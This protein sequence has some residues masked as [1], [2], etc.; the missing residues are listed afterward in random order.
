MNL[1][2]KN[3]RNILRL[4]LNYLIVMKFAI[5]L[6]A[7]V[8]L[9]STYAVGVNAQNISISKKNASIPSLLREIRLQTGYD[10]FFEENTL[11][12][13]KTVT[14]HIKNGSLDEVL[15]TVFKGQPFT[16][17]VSQ[18][19]VIIK[20]RGKV[21]PLKETNLRDVDIKIAGTV[22]DS[23]GEPLVGVSIKVKGTSVGTVTNMS[24]NYVIDASTDAI[25]VF[26]YVG[27][28]TI[29]VPVQGRTAI[30]I[31]MQRDDAAISEVVVVGF[32][33][34]KKESLVG[35][36]S[37]VKAT[38][39]KTPARDLTTVLAGRLA[40]VVATQRSGAPGSD[41]ATL[42]IRGVGT[43][44]SS[45]QG[46]LLVVD[47]VPDRAI[48]NIDPEDIESFTILKDATATAVYGTRGANGV[49]LINTKRGKL[50]K[51]Q[52]NA[53]FNQALTRF[54]LLPEFLDGPE[55][56][57]LYNEG[58]EMR[59][60]APLY[61]TEII[62]NHRSREDPDLY[63]NVDWYSVLFNK[64]GHN[65]RATLN[66]NGGSESATYYISAGYFGEVGLF[67]TDDI[68][69][70]N[71]TL[72]LDRFN[73]TSNVGV[74]ITKST[75][76]ELGINGFIT[77]VN[78]PAYGINQIFALATSTAPHVIPP[79]YSNGLWPQLSGTQIS[80]YMAL[81]QSGINNSYQTAV[82]SNLRVKQDLAMVLDGLSATGMFAFDVN[83]TNS[84]ARSRTLQTYYASGRDDNGDLITSITTPGTEELAFSI[85]RYGDRRFYSEA[86]L[87]YSH[88]FG[89]HDV[90]GLLLFN[91]SDYADATSRVSSYQAAI[92]Y[93][94]RNIVGRANYG[95]DGRYY[96]EANFSY[97][98]SDNFVPGKRF[99]FFPSFGAGW[100][101]SREKWYEGVS[102]YVP[103][104]KLRYTYGLSGNASLNDPD[105]RFLYLTTIGESG[106]YIFG[107]PGSSK[108]V[109]YSE[110]RIGGNVQWET[111]Y[112]QNLGVEMNFLN[113]DLQLIVELFKEDRKGILLRNQTVPYLSGFTA[114]NLPYS[115]IGQTK[116]K[117]IDVTL[118]YNKQWAAD[119]FFTFRGVFNYNK[120]LAVVDGIP[121]Y[122]YDYLNRVGKPISQRFGYVA[123]G[124]FET[125]E[126][127]D[128]A[129]TQ[130]GDVRIG[131]I[132]Y[133]DLNGDGI[134]NSDDRTGIGY[135]AIPRMVYG[136]TFGGGFKGFDLSLFFQGVGMVDFSYESG[137]GTNPFYNGATYGN[138]YRQVLDR[139]TPENPN[140]EAFYP[141]LSTD[142]DNTTNYY[143]SN[144]WV[145]RSDYI[146]LKQA[147]LGYSFTKNQF[148]DRVGMSKLRVYASGTNLLTFS[149]WKFWDPELGDGRGAVYP[150]IS[151]YNVGVR[152]NFK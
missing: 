93:R 116:N 139:W 9:Q 125:Q 8:F 3:V 36:Q 67:K 44:A 129:A 43:Y 32:G 92:P 13:A 18:N 103:Y 86:A 48:N 59:G 143:A 137:Y 34:Q 51:P 87:N 7:T 91:Q 81:T 63:P 126:E 102:D 19:T 6:L 14:I 69:S 106:G 120:N 138:M 122:R 25:L 111:S 2:D 136:L 28:K 10:F 24:G 15:Q 133:K 135:G 101:V 142:R 4:L 27:F 73:F 131:D 54:T 128:N 127:I 113:N 95:Y 123:T 99:G 84:T 90:S 37:T 65:N 52:I 26:T 68:Q 152:A 33:T 49:I 78:R 105:S 5:I 11:N 147:E 17:S 57:T 35:A 12:E 77:N 110:N 61:S 42:L 22:R 85:S 46:P 134:I 121:P 132:R 96:A 23:M 76:L 115:N 74:D 21:K 104:L 130:A 148:L 140:A 82:R 117:G 66:V 109:G 151:T 114:D 47:G 41:G 79:Q 100:V 70:Y 58:L 97:S 83:L 98:G 45:P 55:F 108:T 146:R 31:V 145:Y 56:M 118:E 1:H 75:K 149:P 119:G 38:E 20:N 89:M 50:G 112:R 71:S 144:W 40:G 124:L 150:N 107:Q 62:E 16:Y 64:Y 88:Q 60:R 94:Q 53:E 39:L 29:E 72:K 80:P 30:N 141:R